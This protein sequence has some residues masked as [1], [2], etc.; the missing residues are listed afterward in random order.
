VLREAGV[1]RDQEIVA[2]ATELLKRAERAHPGISGGL[3]GQI[4]VLG[5]GRPV[6]GGVLISGNGNTVVTKSALVDDVT[7][8]LSRVFQSGFPRGRIGGG[9]LVALT[10]LRI[11]L[12]AIASRAF[13]L[14]FVGMAL[15]AAGATS[16]PAP[17]CCLCCTC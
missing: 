2:L 17:P 14:F 16:Q 1:D 6:T 8:H 5:V 10:R 15:L 3:V 11:C 9:L 7:G 12:L 13:P 4:T